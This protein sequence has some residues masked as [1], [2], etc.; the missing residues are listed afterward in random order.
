MN[1]HAIRLI[2]NA[3]NKS[4]GFALIRVSLVLHRDSIFDL[5]RWQS[6]TTTQLVLICE[7]SEMKGGRM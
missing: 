7:L 4:T 3:T 5:G 6:C 1:Q 2:C